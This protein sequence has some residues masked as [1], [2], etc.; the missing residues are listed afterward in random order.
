MAS[1][2]AAS[3][4]AVKSASTAGTL[5]SVIQRD[6][7]VTIAVLAGMTALAWV[8]LVTLA[9]RMAGMDASMDGMAGLARIRP[10]A[11][12]D[13]L[14]MFL[15]WS[16]MMVGM[17]LPSAAP[18]ILLF[19]RV[20]RSSQEKGYPFAPVGMFLSGYLLVWFGFSLGATVFQWGLESAALLSPMMVSTS[21]LLG[22]AILIAAGVYQWTPLKDL[23][24]THCRSSFGFVTH[25]W[26]R[27]TG[28]ALRMGI[29]HG[30]Y[31]LGC[32]WVLMLLLFVGGVMSLL[33]IAAIAGFVLL[34]KTLPFAVPAGRISGL[35]LVASGL[36][37]I[38]KG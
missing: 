4:P 2:E 22:G 34:E 27:G 23:C 8:Y 3:D 16:I 14:L 20:T 19:V 38:F 15:M 36:F 12:V 37:V 33:W 5:E 10:W 11:P 7:I 30:I 1:P 35:A 18:M 6:R 28:G 26:R 32:C 9:M 25:H 21:P 17:M 13:F 24:L 29:D 31:C